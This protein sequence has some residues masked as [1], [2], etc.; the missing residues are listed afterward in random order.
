MTVRRLSGQSPLAADNTHL[1]NLLN[2]KLRGSLQGNTLPNSLTG[3]I[4]VLITS[5]PGIVYST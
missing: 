5:L 3:M 1:H 2:L 4:V